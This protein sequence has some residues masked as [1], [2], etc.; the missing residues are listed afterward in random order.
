M[1]SRGK[2]KSNLPIFSSYFSAKKLSRKQKA[3][4][5]VVKAR[6]KTPA[7]PVQYTRRLKT[8]KQKKL[9]V[10]APVFSGKGLYFRRM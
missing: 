6:T 3:Y 2:G 5:D 10:I 8:R 9:K 7:P 1:G 4:K